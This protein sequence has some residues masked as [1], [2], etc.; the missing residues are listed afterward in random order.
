MAMTPTDNGGDDGNSNR[1]A[2]RRRGP[3]KP[4]PFNPHFMTGPEAI[5]ELDG[6]M[7]RNEFYDQVNDERIPCLDREPGERVRV[8]RD[9]VSQLKE[10]ALRK[11][12]EPREPKK[13]TP[14]R[15]RRSNPDKGEGEA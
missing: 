5:A 11:L 7:S 8:P 4:R 12:D 9:F 15:A 13:M 1:K 3:R 10:R 2:G 6:I 14:I